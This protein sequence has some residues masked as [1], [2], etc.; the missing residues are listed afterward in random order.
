MFDMSF[1]A[2]ERPMLDIAN[3]ASAN[4]S[5]TVYDR[6]M[7]LKPPELS[8]AA[9]ATRAGFS[10]SIFNGIRAHGNPTTATLEKLLDVIGISLGQFTL[11]DQPVLSEVRGTGMGVADV[12]RA[13]RSAEPSKP[14]P[15]LGSAIGGEWED[16]VELTELHLG[17]VL[18]YVARPPSLANDKHAY[19]VTIVGDS[20]APR[21]EPGERAFVSPRAPAS[22][23]DDVIVQ[24]K[25]TGGEDEADRITMVLIKRLVRRTAAFV[26]LRQFNP[27][28]T[29]RVPADRIAAIHRVRGRL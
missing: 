29:F 23:G 3:M 17:E 16:Q 26:E 24:L 7:A 21:F 12:E 28:M 5:N 19:A 9:W 8:K 25:G 1:I 2:V 14:V 6:L 18:D 10:R 22:I 13:W 11:P 27:D 15:L 20:M 4:D